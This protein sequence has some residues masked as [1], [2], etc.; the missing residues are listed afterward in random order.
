MSCRVLL[1]VLVMGLAQVTAQPNHSHLMELY[2]GKKCFELR[3]A[4]L[5]LEP[6]SDPIVLFL[7]GAA[8][9]FAFDT[10]RSNR[11]LRQVLRVSS[12]KGSELH[13]KAYGLL[14]ANAL[15]VGDYASA[16]RHFRAL[17]ENHADH[18]DED[19]VQ[20]YRNIKG[21]AD[22][23][24]RTK[25]QQTKVL[26][27]TF[28][29]K[30]GPN[31][32]WYVPVKAQGVS[33]PLLI[34]TGANFSL[35]AESVARK[36]GAVYVGDGLEVG[37]V[38]TRVIQ[39]R[40]AVIREL[41]IGQVRLKNAV[42]LVL[43]DSSLTMPDQTVLQGVLGFPALCG[44]KEITFHSNGDVFIPRD[45]PRSAPGKALC[46]DG[47]DLLFQAEVQGAS[48]SFQLDSGARTS[49][50]HSPYYQLH[51]VDIE[52]RYNLT[53]EDISG[54]GGTETVSVYQ[55]ENVALRL[56]DKEVTFERISVVPKALGKTPEKTH[57][58]MGRDFMRQ[59]DSL[60]LNFE[61]M[62]LRR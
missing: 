49:I 13:R 53:T 46:L 44:L 35:L 16:S 19:E 55:L 20:G 61:E 2:D 10:Q 25:P 51:K 40:L 8:A 9:Y 27:D 37:T 62:T 59:F 52:R 34:D 38:N 39:P 57:G 36:L 47:F 1:L 30:C 60:T 17:L 12:L 3:E 32:G 4:V 43:D 56:G 15:R 7:R 22:Q 28:I 26:A 41:S 31:E 24:A 5:D 6:S 29:E 58:L 33:I 11:W 42:F 45:A 54:A 48:L 23:L 18:L 21:L 14:A 50:L